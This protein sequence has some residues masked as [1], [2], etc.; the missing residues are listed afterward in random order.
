MK[1][2]TVTIIDPIGIHAR[3]ASA[4]AQTSTKFKSDITFKNND[5]KG[6]AKSVINLMAL[7]I[8][9]DT[10]VEIIVEGPDE[11]EA[12]EALKEL[13]KKENLI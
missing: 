6:N 4:I 9:K 13:M 7:G 10:A 1:T 12:M 5:K 2:L 8:K 11:E 3:P